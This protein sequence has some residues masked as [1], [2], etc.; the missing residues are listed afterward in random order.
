MGVG[1]LEEKGIHHDPAAD[2]PP[3][4][5]DEVGGADEKASKPKLREKIKAK[6]HI[7]HKDKE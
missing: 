4:S 1:L 7:G 3:V 5:K 6:L 2:G